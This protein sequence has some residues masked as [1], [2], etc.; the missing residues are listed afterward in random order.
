MKKEAGIKISDFFVTEA[1][2]EAAEASMNQYLRSGQLFR[3]SE[4]ISE[5]ARLEND[6]ADYM[7]MRFALAVNSC[8]SAIFLSLLSVGVRPGDK[9]IVPAFTFGAVPSAV[10][11]TGATPVLVE[12]GDNYRVDIED[13]RKK[14]NVGIKAV[15]ISHMRGHTSDMDIILKMCSD[16]N[17]PVIE[18]AAHSLGATWSGR[19]VGSMGKVGCFSFQSYKLLNGGEGG[20]LVT[21]DQDIIAKA[22][23]MSGAYEKNWQRHSC[24]DRIFEKYENVLPLYN[25]RLSNL[26]AVVIRSQ[27][28]FIDERVQKGLDKIDF[29]KKMLKN[30]PL[31]SIPEVDKRERQAP[32]S[33]QFNLNGFSDA[34]MRQFMSLVRERGVSLYVFGLHEGNARVFWNWKF[35]GNIPE[36]P[37]TR[38]MLIKACDIR[39]PLTF[40]EDKIRTIA[41]IVVKSIYDIRQKVE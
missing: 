7:G 35:I 25:M 11:H 21:D 41:N 2:P 4:G 15:V 33:I 24:A 32:D 34:E 19:K 5:V 27:I 14:M 9:V 16:W 29:L 38:S 40:G 23:I 3:Y 37:K 17:V 28:P 39:I 12:V 10:V 8:S 20:I 31:I 18:D 6:F 30:C 13:F 36:L 22:V 1:I 26:S